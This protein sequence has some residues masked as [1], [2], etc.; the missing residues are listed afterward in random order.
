MQS[1]DRPEID[2]SEIFKEI[3]DLEYEEF[4]QM[5]SECAET[6]LMGRVKDRLSFYDYA[7]RPTA[8]WRDVAGYERRHALL[9]MSLE[10][11]NSAE[12][13]RYIGLSK[14]RSH[15]MIVRA[16]HER[17][18]K[19]GALDQVGSVMNSEVG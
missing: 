3:L 13:G 6:H 10:T 5:L 8:T 14:Q 12:S 1:Y 17:V 18:N 15:D 16:K 4:H 9:D 19:I 7:A 2:L 11:S